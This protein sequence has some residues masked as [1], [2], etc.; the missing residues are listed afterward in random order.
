[1]YNP[2][3]EQLKILYANL[4][5]VLIYILYWHPI[6]HGM[7]IDLYVNQEASKDLLE[8]VKNDLKYIKKH[9]GSWL[10]YADYWIAI[11]RAITIIMFIVLWVAW[12]F[13]V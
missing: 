5:R 10:V 7:Y 3:I 11:V 8:G 6:N 2:V 13:S 1:M 4:K 9:N 12:R